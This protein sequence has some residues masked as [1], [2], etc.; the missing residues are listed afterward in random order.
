MNLVVISG[1]LA[2][3]PELKYIPN[4]GKAVTTFDIA[5]ENRYSK[6]KENK[7]D[8]F[9]VQCW[10]KLAE[11]IAENLEKGRKILVNGILKNNHWTDE[12]NNYHRQEIVIATKIE[13]LDY[14]KNNNSQGE[15]PPDMEEVEGELP[16]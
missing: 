5:V 16:F 8:F 12:N 6:E 9:R 13:Y 7:P 2:K 14:S 4:S 11:S 1:R 10:G 15:I 3:D